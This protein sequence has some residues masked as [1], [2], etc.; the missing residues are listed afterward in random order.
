MD[1]IINNAQYLNLLW[2]AAAV[3]VLL[4]AG[5]VL[6]SRAQNRFADA[7]MW[8]YL[9]PNDNPALRKVRAGLL[10]ATLAAMALAM[11]DLRWGKRWTQLPQRGIDCMFVVDVSRSMLARDARPNR[12]ER[13][14]QNIRDV[15][16]E[17]GG[18]RAGLVVFAGKAKQKVPLTSNYSD[19][20][21]ALEELAP[22][23]VPRGGSQI[24]EAI[25]VASNCFVDKLP[26]HKAII[27]FSDGEDQ[28]SYP[29]EAAKKAHEDKGIRVFAVGLGDA[30]DGARIPVR[31][32]GNATLYQKYQGKEVFSKMKPGQL[33]AIALAGGGAFIPAGTKQVNMTDVYHR[34]IAEIPR[35]EFRHTRVNQYI[36]RYQW[37]VGAALLLLLLETFLAK[38]GNSRRRKHPNWLWDRIRARR[39]AS[40]H[41]LPKYDD[42]SKKQKKTKYTIATIVAISILAMASH[43]V[44]ADSSN[45][46]RQKY[47]QSVEEYR[48]GQYD[49]ARKLLAEAIAN[50]DASLEAKAKF[51]L[52][53]CDYA[54][55][56]Q[57]V[58]KKEKDKAIKLLENAITQYTEALEADGNDT[59]ARANI[60]LAQRLIDDLKKEQKQQQQ[61]KNRQQK[62][63]KNQKQKQEKQQNKS[64]V[65][66]DSQNPKKQDQDKQQQKQ[67][68]SAS[69]PSTNAKG[70]S[71]AGDQA[72]ME[73]RKA[74]KRKVPPDQARRMLQAVRDRN[75]KRRREKLRQQRAIEIPVE[76]DW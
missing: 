72:H 66:S 76:K 18:D 52:G 42:S 7:G 27:L 46:S 6:R 13:A 2:A 74:K 59:D 50:S 60:E 9:L 56:L 61:K 5:L 28:A 69:Q 54:A 49:Q 68:T 29:A 48:K 25:R 67:K 4:V 37:F 8:Q 20:R 53:N 43:S 63:N 36:P 32:I 21:M 31:N 15:M 39:R 55:A 73:P 35:R 10:A 40:K 14:K 19:I 45:A 24:G 30:K 71:Q 64:Q 16:D 22:Q 33:K 12:L 34:H 57:H 23:S 1:V 70:K 17:M 26:N 47:N 62:Q 38:R 51:N 44:R 41:I 58:T 11:A 3:G 75:L 65:K